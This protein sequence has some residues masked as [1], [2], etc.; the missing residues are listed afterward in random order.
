MQRNINFK[1]SKEIKPNIDI[2]KRKHVPTME[3]ILPVNKKRNKNLIIVIRG[4]IRDSFQDDRLNQLMVSLS[5]KYNVSIY[6]HTWNILQSDKSWRTIEK[7]DTEVTETM[8]HNY[9]SVKIKRIIIQDEDRI[10]LIGKREGYI[11]KTTCP[12]LCWKNMW[13][14]MNEVINNVTES[15]ETTVVNIRFDIFTIRNRLFTIPSIEKIIDKNFNRYLMNII[16]ISKEPVIGIDNLMLG[17]VNSMR[18]FI[19]H[20]HTNLDS[21]LEKY[22]DEHNQEFIVLKENYLIKI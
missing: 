7:N 6:I 3:Y 12:V 4:H 1:V 8:I 21:I 9:F 20:F 2:T 10:E 16:F 19:N 14:G 5:R 17:S 18:R 15:L 13:H 11:G 22:T